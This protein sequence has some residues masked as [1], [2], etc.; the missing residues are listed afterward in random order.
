MDYLWPVY[1]MA[2]GMTICLTNILKAKNQFLIIIIAVVILMPGDDVH[3]CTQNRGVG[4]L[5]LI[6]LGSTYPC[7]KQLSSNPFH[8]SMNSSRQ[9]NRDDLYGI[10]PCSIQVQSMPNPCNSSIQDQKLMEK[11]DQ[12]NW[13]ILK[14]HLEYYGSLIVDWAW[15]DHR[16]NRLWKHLCVLKIIPYKVKIIKIGICTVPKSG[17]FNHILPFHRLIL[18]ERSYICKCFEWE[19]FVRVQ[20]KLI[21]HFLLL[22]KPFAW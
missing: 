10:N 21:I 9:S 16:L 11:S 20:W 15:I 5:C 14:W 19:N 8:I 7:H 6:C 3:G 2:P 13:N 22:A 18:I 1:L 4:F 12:S 17:R